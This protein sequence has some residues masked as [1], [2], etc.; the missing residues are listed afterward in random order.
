MKAI[1]IMS[2]W[3]EKVIHADVIKADD[4]KLIIKDQ[5]RDG[6]VTKFVMLEDLMAEPEIEGKSFNK[7]V[8]FS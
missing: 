6:W 8:S 7:F 5:H 1:L 4:E 2:D 3:S